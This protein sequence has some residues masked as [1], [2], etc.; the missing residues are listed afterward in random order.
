M[1]PAA[2]KRHLHRHT[3]TPAA[4]KRSPHRHTIMAP[5]QAGPVRPAAQAVGPA[6]RPGG[7]GCATRAA[8]SVSRVAKNTRPPRA[9]QVA[10][11]LRARWSRQSGVIAPRAPQ[12]AGDDAAGRRA[13]SEYG[14]PAVRGS[15][16]CQSR[17]GP[18]DMSAF[19]PLIL[20]GHPTWTGFLTGTEGHILRGIVKRYR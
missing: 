3:M 18:F 1:T 2:E 8:T 19:R 5:A 9:G 16:R 11:S 10:L 13:A 17:P 12:R 7:T 20:M 6:R 4:E 14:G 15:G